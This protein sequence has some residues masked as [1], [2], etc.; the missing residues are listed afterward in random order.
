MYLIKSLLI[1]E[2][3]KLFKRNQFA[4]ILNSRC[5]QKYKL[6]KKKIMQ[7]VLVVIQEFKE[8]KMVIMMSLQSHYKEI[9]K[10]T[11]KKAF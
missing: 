10:Q 8:E 1:K 7:E 5:V 3:R 2:K 4:K 11:L 6:I 9:Q